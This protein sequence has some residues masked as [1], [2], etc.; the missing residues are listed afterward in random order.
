MA[1]VDSPIGL[2]I[3]SAIFDLKDAYRDRTRFRGSAMENLMMQPVK[4]IK[5]LNDKQGNQIYIKIL[6]NV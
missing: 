3:T 2:P 5:L 4:T 6:I 1:A